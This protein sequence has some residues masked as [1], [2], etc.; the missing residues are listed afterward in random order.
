MLSFKK[1]TLE[2]ID[3]LRPYFAHSQSKIC[4][5]TVGGTFMWR[6]FFSVEYAEAH[7]ALIFKVVVKYHGGATAFT[8]PLG[9]DVAGGIEEVEFYCRHYKI[10]LKYCT[11][12]QCDMGPLKAAYP[13]F[14][15]HLE[16]DWSD[17]L[18]RAEDIVSLA[19]R[20]YSGQRNHI[21]Y[22]KKSY[23]EPR[24]EEITAANIGEV[25]AF[26][27]EFNLVTNKASEIFAE[28]RRKTIEVLEN[29][30]AYGLLGG[31]I[32]AEG[33]VAAFA[34]GEIWQ[35]V[36]FVHIEKANP[37]IR[38]AYQVI[39]NEFAKHFVSPGVEFVNR[40]EDVGDM[41]LRTSKLSYHPCELIDKYIVEV[42]L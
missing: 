17:Y 20:K 9:G 8:V 35:G 16:A 29:Y 39:N 24:F 7:G 6:D 34:A 1:L 12:T 41:G 3:R 11:V 40:E 31:L 23:S 15:L 22:F 21:N 14:S 42:E 18:Y 27:D 36:L 10:P 19:G 26:Y 33:K 4:D 32:R 37:E 13:V 25:K 38:G 2:D 28:E 5:N 30:N